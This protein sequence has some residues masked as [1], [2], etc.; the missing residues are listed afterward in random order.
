MVTRD[1]AMRRGVH[2]D[3]AHRIDAERAKF[4]LCGA[5]AATA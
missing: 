5:A 4:F 3:D 2:D 1:D